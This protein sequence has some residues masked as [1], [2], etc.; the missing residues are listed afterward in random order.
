MEKNNVIEIKNISP[1]NINQKKSP[2]Y[3]KTVK[4]S[5]VQPYL[6]KGWEIIPS[7]FK[8]SE[9]LKREKTHNVA[10]EDRVWGLCA[11]MGFNYINEN[12]KFKL[13]YD[14]N[15]SKQID[16]FSYDNEVIVII[17]CKSSSIRKGGSYQK[18]INSKLSYC[19]PL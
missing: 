18:D 2:Y 10:F 5:T 15:L 11:K 6:D 16:V 4:K 17:E 19:Q 1:K 13:V 9:K 14:G 7:K 3:F 12:D 8:K